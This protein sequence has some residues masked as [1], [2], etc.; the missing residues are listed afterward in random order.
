M[1]RRKGLLNTRGCKL[2]TAR[3]YK[4]IGKHC[5]QLEEKNISSDQFAAW[6][7]AWIQPG[8]EDGK[9]KDEMQALR[10]LKC[11]IKR[12]HDDPCKSWDPCVWADNLHRTQE[13][14]CEST[15]SS[16]GRA[17]GSLAG[18]AMGQVGCFPLLSCQR[19][20]HNA[21]PTH[22]ITHLHRLRHRM[23]QTHTHTHT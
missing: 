4:E 10:A 13:R 21:T 3:L 7:S 20:Q 23:T 12:I 15:V 18:A 5:E 6:S 16:S 11:Q 1:S 19:R 17:I 8:E 2:A 14:I 22:T 9:H